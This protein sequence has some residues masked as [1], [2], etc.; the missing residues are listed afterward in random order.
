MDKY[1]AVFNVS[2]TNQDVKFEW[3]ELGLTAVR[4]GVR[5]LWERKDI[6]IAENLSRQL[7]AVY[8]PHEPGSRISGVYER[9]VTTPTA[10]LAVIRR[11][12]TFTIAPWKPAL[13]PMRGRMVTGLI[14]PNRVVWT[15]DR[16]R[17]LPGRS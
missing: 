10:K 12:D 1:V 4:Y 17:A 7:N 8:L 9:V 14:G 6:G 16:G 13:E 3:K 11:E 2:D 5:D 15:L